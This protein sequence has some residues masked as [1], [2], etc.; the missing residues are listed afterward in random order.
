MQKIEEYVRNQRQEDLEYNQMSQKE[1]M[2]MFMR[3]PVKRHKL[4]SLGLDGNAMHM[5]NLQGTL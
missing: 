4:N 2:D 5:A 1:Y 3:E